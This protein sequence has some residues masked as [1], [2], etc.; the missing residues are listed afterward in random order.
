MKRDR[1]ISLCAFL[2][3][4]SASFLG[5]TW[6]HAAEDVPEGSR[7]YTADEALTPVKEGL[8]DLLSHARNILHILQGIN[9]TRQADERAEELTAEF[10]AFLDTDDALNDIVE[11]TPAPAMEK[12][13]DKLSADVAT[14]KTLMGE[15]PEQLKRIQAKSCYHSE[16]LT[17]AVRP[18]C[19]AFLPNVELP[20][21]PEP[22]QVNAEQVELLTRMQASD[23]E[24]LLK[25][26]PGKVQGGPGF[27]RQSAWVLLEE[28]EEAVSLEYDILRTFLHYPA[29]SAQAL[30]MEGGKVYDKHIIAMPLRGGLVSF[31]QWFDITK[32][33]RKTR[34]DSDSAE[35]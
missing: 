29:P 11:H 10:N 9:S 15:M 32:Y 35:P 7:I 20:P 4:V 30:V 1:S 19:E 22:K 18:V 8:N 34:A 6:L 24:K 16:K 28:N 25:E 17:A 13:V 12:L 5:G 33:W 31:E 14:F 21:G 26:Q 3:C 27:S 2:A 23:R